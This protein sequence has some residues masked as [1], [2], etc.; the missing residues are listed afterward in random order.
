MISFIY[1]LSF[2]PHNAYL[3]S[4]Q[5]WVSGVK[6]HLKDYLFNRSQ[7]VNF[8]GEM[9]SFK[10]I[11]VGVLQG[12]ILG[13]LLFIVYFND[14]S[15]CLKYSITVKYA[16]DTVLYVGNLPSS[17]LSLTMIWKHYHSGARKMS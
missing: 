17:S 8:Q 7:C 15:D 1:I 11:T 9:S 3:T 6:H 5:K 2:T 16:D 12:T 13:P 10:P 14:L 4:F